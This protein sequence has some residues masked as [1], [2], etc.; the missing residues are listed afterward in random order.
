MDTPEPWT[1]PA[2]RHME[3]V[4]DHAAGALSLG[5][6]IIHHLRTDTEAAGSLALDE[7]L[8][9]LAMQMNAAAENLLAVQRRR[10]PRW[11]TLA[12][13]EDVAEAVADAV[14]AAE[15]REAGQ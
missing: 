8:A 13:S 4:V 11:L 3:A 14:A 15:A 12:Q 1:P 10:A 2:P 6:A 5:A 9:W 7:G